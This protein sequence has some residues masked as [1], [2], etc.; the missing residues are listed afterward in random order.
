MSKTA[1]LV[2]AHP[3]PGSFVTA[4]RDTVAATLAEA[5]YDLLQSD[6][7]AMNFNPVL[8]AKDFG[9]RRDEGHLTVALEQR[10]NHEQATLAPDISRE[11]DKVVRAD[12]IVFTFPLFWFS[13]PAILKGWIDRVFISGP[14]Y[15]GK[16]IYGRGGM[17]GKVATAAFSLGGRRDMFGPEGIH[18]DHV[19]GFLR[20]FFQ[21]SLG[22]VGMDVIEPF[23]AF[24][25][26]YIG[27]EA[28]LGLLRD[29]HDHF[30]DLHARP[31]MDMPNLAR[32]DD[33]FRPLAGSEAP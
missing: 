10:H 28:R 33:R 13:V 18:G 16:S 26:P 5:G 2:H 31:R 8:S 21:G 15:G 3:E 19:G 24:H 4:M 14:F 29:L 9:S 20:S 7:Y 27:Q 32:F 25:A 22:Y 11:I 23:V 17:V 12:L 6:L 1:L 30:V